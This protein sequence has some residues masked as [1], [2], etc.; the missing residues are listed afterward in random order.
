M[1]LTLSIIRRS[2]RT[3]PTKI[4]CHSWCQQHELLKR[5]ILHHQVPR[6]WL[7]FYQSPNRSGSQ[8]RTLRLLEISQCLYQFR[9]SL[10]WGNQG[11]CLRGR[12]KDPL[13][14][15]ILHG[16]RVQLQRKEGQ[17]LWNQIHIFGQ[18]RQADFFDVVQD[19]WHFERSV[20]FW[21]CF[22]QI[23]EDKF[24]YQPD[25]GKDLLRKAFFSISERNFI[26]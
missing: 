25:S 15:I 20:G 6:G 7:L 9:V 12:T 21:R 24:D 22:E 8:V 26:V 17:Q 5:L 14:S 23:E 18:D 16:P 10:R 13:R 4:I 3:S 2:E 1:V 11:P 19:A